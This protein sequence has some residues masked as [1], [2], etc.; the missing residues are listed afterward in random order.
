MPLGH[1]AAVTRVIG[2]RQIEIDH[3]NWAYPG[4]VARGVVA[5]DVSERNDWTA[6]RVQIGRG[7]QLGSVY[8]TNGFI[9]G[10]PLELGPPR[11]SS[12]RPASADELQPQ[13]QVISVA[14]AL[15]GRDPHVIRIAEFLAERRRAISAAEVTPAPQIQL[16]RG[17]EARR[18]L[19][20]RF[21]TAIQ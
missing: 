4:A 18:A 11:A 10:K 15:A 9:Y 13:P 16:Q 14:A 1:V 2:H 17:R 8:P 20:T 7:D 6:V 3:A 5:V 21:I 19:Q 12:N